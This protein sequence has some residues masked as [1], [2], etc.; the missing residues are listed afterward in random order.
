LTAPNFPTNYLTNITVNFGSLY[1]VASISTGEKPP[2]Q[3]ASTGG[4]FAYLNGGASPSGRLSSAN[5]KGNSVAIP[6]RGSV[7]I[8]AWSER[9]FWCG[10]LSYRIR[11]LDENT[12]L[13]RFL[14][15]ALK[16]VERDIINLQQS[17][18]IPAL[19]KGPLS[20]VRVPIPPIHVQREIV[21]NLNAFTTLEAELEAELAARKIQLGHYRDVLFKFDEGSRVQWLSLGDFADIGTGSRNTNQAEELGD[22]PFFV[23]SQNALL[24][25]SFDF[26]EKAIVTAGDGVG[27]GKVLHYVDGKYALHQRAYRIAPKDDRVLAKYLFHFMKQDFSLYLETTSVHASV[28]SLRKPMFEKYKV[29]VP[30]LERQIEIITALDVLENLISDSDSGIPAELAARRK[31]YEYY[32]AEL[33]T[34]KEA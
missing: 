5:T 17:G 22:Y 3:I 28:T 6:S 34:F 26:D 12:L 1:E 21:N 20:K 25:S 16:H 7:G 11:S 31:Q 18:S 8:V 24:A 23:R 4:Q 14:Y 27:V 19:N 32:R 9:E 33:L 30:S 13:T 10:P 2:T 15:F 29:P